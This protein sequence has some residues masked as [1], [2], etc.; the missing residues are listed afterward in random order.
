[1]QVGHGVPIFLVHQS[2]QDQAAGEAVFILAH[3]RVPNPNWIPRF[4]REPFVSKPDR[5]NQNV[6]SDS[7]FIFQPIRLQNKPEG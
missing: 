5:N 2:N 1:M 3:R 6:S 4:P 7:P